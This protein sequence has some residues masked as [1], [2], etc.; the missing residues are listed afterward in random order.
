MRVRSFLRYAD[1]WFADSH[2]GICVAAAGMGGALR[3]LYS[4]K[5]SVH[6]ERTQCPKSPDLVCEHERSG[7]CTCGVLAAAS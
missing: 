5:H 2:F 4:G 7:T 1:N 6:D 3:K